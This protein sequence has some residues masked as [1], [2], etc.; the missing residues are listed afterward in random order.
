MPNTRLDIRLDQEIKQKAE[1][2]TALLGLKSLTEY[3]TQLMDQ[4]ASEVIAQHEK[5]VIADPVF[6]RFMQA[7]DSLSQP[8]AALCEALAF[9][10]EQ[11]LG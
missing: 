5:M 1:K 8:N 9:T 4:D 7:C 6:D 2:A 10:K 11:G 3:V